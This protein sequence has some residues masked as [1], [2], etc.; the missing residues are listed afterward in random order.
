MSDEMKK[1]ILAVKTELKADIVSVRTELDRVNERW[2]AR[3]GWL[4]GITT[5][6]ARARGDIE[7]LKEN[8]ISRGEFRAAMDQ[9]LGRFD[10]F[11]S[12]SD[13]FRLRWSVQSDTLTRHH[14]RL[15]DHEKRLSALEPK[16]A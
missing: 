14:H 10:G 12:K 2:D 6:Q 4:R 5:E 16:R 8:M 1:L 15:E 13:E 3:D 9:I 11:A 7:W